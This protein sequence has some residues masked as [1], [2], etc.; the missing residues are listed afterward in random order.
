MLPV[1]TGAAA[2]AVG[3]W[4]NSGT[5]DFGE[6]SETVLDDAFTSGESIQPRRNI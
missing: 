3:E 5:L 1:P 4:T 6:E 2:E